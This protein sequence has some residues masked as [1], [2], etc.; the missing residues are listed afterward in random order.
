MGDE[1]AALWR[2][3]DARGMVD[4]LFGAGGRFATRWQADER[5][6]AAL[7]VLVEQK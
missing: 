5:E 2:G 6:R 7:A 4:A 3:N 1:L